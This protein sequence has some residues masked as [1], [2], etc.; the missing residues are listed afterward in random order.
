MFSK[1]AGW[2]LG[3]D[4]LA[5]SAAR[6]RA[7]GLPV[8]DLTD[9]NPT[10]C[11][12]RTAGEQLSLALA[13]V[14]NDPRCV[15]YSP[16][17]RGER[18][19]REIIAAYHAAQGAD[20]R[21]ESVVVTAGTS[22]GYSHLFRLLADPGDRVLVPAPSYPLFSLLAGLEGVDAAPYPLRH[23]AGR[24]HID[25]EAI[26]DAASPPV[27]ALLLVHPNNPTGSLASRDEADTVRRLCR[28]RGLALVSDEVFSDYRSAST[29]AD[30]PVT[31]LPSPRDAESAPLTFVLSGASKLL[32][33]P[34]LKVGWIVAAG[35][36]RLRD[37]ALAR[38][39]VI[40]DTYL[41]VS[42]LTQLA[43]VDLFGARAEITREIAERVAGNRDRV[44]RAVARSGRVRLLE[45]DGGWYAILQVSSDAAGT[46]P[47][48]DRIVR[49][50]LDGPGVLVQPGWLFDLEPQD[51]TGASATHLVISLLPDPELLRA[52]LER[53]LEAID[54]TAR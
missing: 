47:D 5:E 37:E 30:A 31:L 11:G 39:E 2:D 40:A 49:A 21:A 16:D 3:S 14:A 10:R 1:R 52:G 46:A 51:E 9:S 19:A 6:R 7:A 32:G 41:S 42:P 25:L 4:D 26:R 48:E 18:A 27:R 22:E 29:P 38:L 20:A 44:A 33:L 8:L 54:S 12:L 34:Q 50:L 24:W 23:R 45:A 36:A 43:L 17:P 53:V 15:V 13:R 28:E 35:P